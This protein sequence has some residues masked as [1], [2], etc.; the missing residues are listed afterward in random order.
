MG[1]LAD[2][3]GPNMKIAFKDKSF[4]VDFLGECRQSDDDQLKETTAW[5]QAKGGILF[6]DEA[7]RL[8]QPKHE[9]SRDFGLEALEEIMSAMDSGKIAVI[10]AGYSKPMQ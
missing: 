8:M 10:F 4:Y 2:T 6:V 1:D 5:T 3:L 9:D 7:Y